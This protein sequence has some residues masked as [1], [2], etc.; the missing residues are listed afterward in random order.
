MKYDV[1]VAVVGGGPA[2]AY[3]AL[4]LAQRGICATVFDASHPREK[5]CGGG[6][7]A[8]TLEKFP[9]L[10]RFRQYGGS[11]KSLKLISCTDRTLLVE[12]DGGFNI[13]RRILDQGILDLALNAG[14][15]LV[16]ERVLSVDKVADTWA[17][18]TS[19]R[20]LTA[21][22]VVGADGV[23]SVVR[24]KTVGP[25]SPQN[26][27]ITYGYLVTG[28][29]QEPTTIKYL[30]EVP[31]YIWNFPRGDHSCIGV[32]SELQFGSQLK[33]LLDKFISTHYPRAKFLSKFAAL[34]PAANTP[35]FFELPCVG[36]DWLLAGDAA[37]HVDPITGGGLLYA[38]WSGKLAAEAIAKDDLTLYDRCWRDQYGS[39]L[40]HQCLQRKE[41]FYAPTVDLRFALY[42]LKKSG[43][44]P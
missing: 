20:V 12:N 26:L 22:I 44:L 18:T 32:G 2:G 38:L 3:C 29:E 43:A 34:I 7:S 27:A 16:R 40:L 8:Y 37:G 15:K 21:K 5:A 39:Y 13:S 19:K 31:G 28:V 4:Q 17:I 14:C 36:P 6:I 25:I 42:A 24:A 11:P 10:E 9:F 41:F 30:A 33:T 1:E 35:A 23:Q